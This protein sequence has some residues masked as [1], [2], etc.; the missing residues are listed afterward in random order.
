MTW[1]SRV[2]QTVKN[3]PGFSGDASGKEPACQRRRRKRLGFDPGVG[4]VPLK[5]K[6]QPT[7]VFLLENSTDR[8]A[9]WTMVHGAAKSGTRLSE[10]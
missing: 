8:G 9:W 5:R 10:Q 1:A 4:K 2:A 6:W 3:L 7:L